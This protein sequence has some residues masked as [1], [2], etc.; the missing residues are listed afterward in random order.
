MNPGGPLHVTTE[1]VMDSLRLQ[2][3]VVQ[4]DTELWIW[5]ACPLLNGFMYFMVIC[6]VWMKLTT[7]LLKSLHNTDK[8]NVDFHRNATDDLHYILLFIR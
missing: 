3:F 8:G 2:K 6:Y 7:G 1:T 4:S 5:K